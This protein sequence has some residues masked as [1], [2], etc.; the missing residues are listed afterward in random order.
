MSMS[1]SFFFLKIICIGIT[2]TLLGSSFCQFLSQNF[3]I[4]SKGWLQ[5]ELRSLTISC[6]FTTYCCSLHLVHKYLLVLT[7]KPTLL[8]IPTYKPNPFLLQTYSIPPNLIGKKLEWV[9]RYPS[10][11]CKYKH[12]EM[13]DPTT[14]FVKEIV[15]NHTKRIQI[16]P[17]SNQTTCLTQVKSHHTCLYSLGFY[18]C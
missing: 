16:F 7:N 14:M 12:E 10:L 3:H 4:H 6:N 17:K 9:E 13:K 5:N 1:S 2:N 11:A 15:V 18:M 8:S